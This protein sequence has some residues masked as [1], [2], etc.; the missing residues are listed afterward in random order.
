MFDLIWGSAE[1]LI[2]FT[3]PCWNGYKIHRMK[4][5]YKMCN[6]Q[7]PASNYLFKVSNGN[8]RTRCEIC[9][10]LTIKTPEYSQSW[11]KILRDDTHMTSVKIVQ[12]SGPPIFLVHPRPKLFY[13]LTLDVQFQTNTPLSKWEPIN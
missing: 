1:I 3:M 5:R 8:T 12:F 10:K 2:H 4:V 11:S 13:P 6:T 9:S 7:F